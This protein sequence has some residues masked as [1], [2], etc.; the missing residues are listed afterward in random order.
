MGQKNGIEVRYSG[1]KHLLSEVRTSINKDC[2]A[3]ML[4]EHA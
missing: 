2:K 3:F 1:T 4:Y